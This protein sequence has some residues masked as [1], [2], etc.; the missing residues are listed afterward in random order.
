[1][2]ECGVVFLLNAVEQLTTI[3]HGLHQSPDMRAE[4]RADEKSRIA[5]SKAWTQLEASGLEITDVDLRFKI[6]GLKSQLAGNNPY[7]A[8]A[9]IHQLEGIRSRLK[10]LIGSQKFARIP[11]QVTQYFEQEQLFGG[12]VYDFFPEA[13]D[14]IK[15]AGNSLA[16]SLHDACVF[17]LMRASEHGLRALARKLRVKLTHKGKSQPIDTATWDEVISGVRSKLQNAHA[18][19]HTPARAK[20]MKF[21]ADLAERCSLVRDIWRNDGMHT[22]ASYGPRDAIAAFEHVKGF[23]QLL[24]E[25]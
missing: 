12:V 25:I 24:C 11:H 5:C 23:M 15:N 14:D 6:S 22:R 7:S 10:V 8:E 19:A 13:R 16:V 9:L 2:I 21:Y 4:M 3:I 1:M 20:K 18:M 17:H